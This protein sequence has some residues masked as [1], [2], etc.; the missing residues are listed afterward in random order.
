MT[1]REAI[2]RLR[3]LAAMRDWAEFGPD[4]VRDALLDVAEEAL[5]RNYHQVSECRC[6]ECVAFRSLAAAVGGRG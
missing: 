3:S 5:S 6:A 1:P 2:D 4:P